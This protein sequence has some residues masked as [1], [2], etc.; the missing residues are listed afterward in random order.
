VMPPR[1]G[2]TDRPLRSRSRRAPWRRMG[3]LG[4]RVATAATAGVVAALGWTSF[5]W[6][7]SLN[8]AIAI[9]SVFIFC[10]TLGIYLW[11]SPAFAGSASVESVSS[12]NPYAEVAKVALTTQGLVLG[13]ISFSG[14]SVLN[15]TLK[16]G[17]ASL[18]AGVL[19]A[20]VMYLLVAQ[21]APTDRNRRLAASVLFS[22]LLWALEFGLIC[23]VA[24]NW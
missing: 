4:F 11:E 21:G 14:P 19:I 17:S 6:E 15:L 12:Q 1:R 2:V 3:L 20:S 24:G 7:S 5:G 9:M 16:V 8:V 13:L 22:V 23:V 10:E 18:A